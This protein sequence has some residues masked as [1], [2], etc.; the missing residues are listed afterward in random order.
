M[1]VTTVVWIV[2]V[3]LL[4]SGLL[5]F[6]PNR[7]R[8]D[9][10][11]AV[12]VTP[13]FR[14]SIDARRILGRYRAIVWGSS[15]IA[16]A[17][18]LATAMPLPMIL[19]QSVGILW[20]LVSSHGRALAYAATPTGVLEIDLGAPRES[21]PGGPIVALLPVASLGML[22]VWA[23]R[24]LDRLPDRLPVHWG[25]QGADHWVTTTATSVSVFLV[26]EASACLLL[27]SLAW[28]V[29][30]RSRRISTSGRAAAGERQFRQRMVQMLI[31]CGYLLA[32]SAWFA[33]LMPTN[34]TAAIWG[35]V[36][37]VVILA[38]VVSLFLAGQGGARTLVTA[39]ATPTGD[40]TPDA[41][42]KWG[43]FYVNAADPSILVEK[44]FGIGYTVNLG[45]RWSWVAL[46][47][48]MVPAALGLVFLR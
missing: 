9:I 41:C 11:F 22:A 29:L 19:I 42:W 44:R 48:M 21:I 16:I 6:M 34:G 27:V 46:G 14:S 2:P 30:N 32:G 37:G 23:A 28:G 18:L 24:H 10:F 3:L 38:F 35:V 20:A 1:P 43:L 45:N 17:V 13:E 36:F 26:I 33:I 12:T 47:A 15:L 25:I 31:V 5:H 39:G 7:T 8:A 40:R 4:I